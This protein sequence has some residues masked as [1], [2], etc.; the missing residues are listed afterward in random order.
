MYIKAVDENDAVYKIFLQQT[1]YNSDDNYDLA[2]VE[3]ADGNN[4]YT[5]NGNGSILYE[6][7]EFIFDNYWYTVTEDEGKINVCCTKF[8]KNGSMKSTVYSL[9]N[10]EWSERDEQCG[11]YFDEN[12]TIVYDTGFGVVSK[13]YI[14]MNT[15][16]KT[17]AE[18]DR[19]TMNDNMS[20]Q[21]VL[22]KYIPK[23]EN[24]IE[25]AKSLL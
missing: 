5:V 7:Y 15:K 25:T 1:A 23:A 20:Q 3:I 8:E 18:Y 17:I 14:Q 10:G 22:A 6:D 4:V 21:K 13:S 2:V 12:D 16:N 19:S 24:S 11:F 9:A